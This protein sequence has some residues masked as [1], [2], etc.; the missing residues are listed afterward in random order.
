MP[1][2]K[3]PARKASGSAR[4]SSAKQAALDRFR[5]DPDGELLTTDQGVRINDDQ[6]SLKASAR[7]PSL[8]EDFILREKIT[9]QQVT[10]S[11]ALS[12]ADTVKDTATTRK[13]AILA[14]DGVEDDAV[15]T[16]QRALT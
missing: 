2:K 12:M 6:N 11:Q 5:E 1:S 9:H 3:R 16:M 4:P 7:G 15:G 10:R 14:A 8:L 13:V